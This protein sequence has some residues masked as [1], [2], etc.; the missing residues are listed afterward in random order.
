MDNG[1]KTGM[2]QLLVPYLT[3]R[4][5]W[6]GVVG[7]IGRRGA[8]YIRSEPVAPHSP[9]NDMR[10]HF[11]AFDPHLEGPS[12][13]FSTP[14]PFLTRVPHTSSCPFRSSVQFWRVE[15]IPEGA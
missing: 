7:I 5:Y 13:C 12:Y 10:H 1:M 4:L 2:K 14:Q 8:T 9:E 3:I 11:D 6:N 15:S